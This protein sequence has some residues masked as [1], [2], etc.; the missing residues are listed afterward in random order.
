MIVLTSCS[1]KT[2]YFVRYIYKHWKHRKAVTPTPRTVSHDH[3]ALLSILY[4]LHSLAVDVASFYK[5]TA[6]TRRI[7]RGLPKPANP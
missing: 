1:I 4:H 2:T 5:A 7:Y 6:A 3:P